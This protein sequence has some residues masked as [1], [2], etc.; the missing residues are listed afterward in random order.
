MGGMA[1]EERAGEGDLELEELY[2]RYAPR[3]RRLCQRRLGDP[4]RA[5]D[6]CHEALIRASQA[7]GSFRPGSAVWPWLA[8]IA[9]NVCT[10]ME[11]RDGRID[12][13]AEPP[14]QVGV[15]D[16]V[17]EAGL[18]TRRH[19]VADALKS[20]PLPHRRFLFLHHF[21]GLTYEEIAE[22]EGTTAGAVRSRLMRARRL[23]RTRIEE[24]ATAR[25]DWPLPAAGW[26]RN[27]TGRLRMAIG[28]VDATLGD[29]LG[30]AG[31]YAAALLFAVAVGTGGV[32][33][34]P[35]GDT[36]GP[37]LGSGVQT[38][39]PGA[40]ASRSLARTT[41]AVVRG[42][43]REVADAR[44]PPPPSVR[45]IRY[46]VEPIRAPERVVGI[47]NPVGGDQIF[48]WKC[49]SATREPGTVGKLVCE[50]FPNGFT[51]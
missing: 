32:G 12:F 14:E 31:Q 29:H 45:P 51:P 11:R 7:A 22:A 9:A 39:G 19:L 26:L 20:L 33:G 40:A 48:S 27:R 10:D 21:G 6:A 28:R 36:D 3:L 18:R 46:L 17:V 25:G 16:P 13:V 35:A 24:L 15:S 49:G 41:A 2:R 47:D 4:V 38:G 30:T 8:T 43:A 34:G 23:L 44:I 37:G 1:V 5:E 42:G 50:M